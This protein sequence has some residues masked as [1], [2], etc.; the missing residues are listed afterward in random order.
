MKC[1]REHKE[2]QVF[3]LGGIILSTSCR[4]GVNHYRA[5]ASPA[6]ISTLTHTS[7][8][9]EKNRVCHSGRMYKQPQRLLNGWDPVPGLGKSS[10]QRKP[11]GCQLDHLLQRRRSGGCPPR[12][13]SFRKKK[14]T[15][16]Y[17]KHRKKGGKKER[18][19]EG[20]S[21]G[22]KEEREEGRRQ[23]WS[24]FSAPILLIKRSMKRSVFLS[25]PTYKP[26]F[27]LLRS[28]EKICLFSLYF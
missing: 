26:F 27:F 3:F 9:L 17:W 12:S 28:I 6:C 22:R 18:G 25:M 2:V 11:S 20:R 5:S 24:L 15:Q 13:S 21:K 14:K 10:G 19:M 23:K 4:T 1:S 16:W 8:A 7:H